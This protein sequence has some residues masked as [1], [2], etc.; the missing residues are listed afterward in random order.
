[1]GKITLLVVDDIE[2]NR[3]I[4]RK[5]FEDNYRILQASNGE[6][7]MK[8]VESESVEIV[9]TD[10]FMEP[11]NGYELIKHIR[12]KEQYR[13]IPIIAVTESD[14]A[15]RKKALKAGADDLIYRPFIR[16]I[17]HNRVEGLLL[18]GYDLN[19]YKLAYENNPIPF[20]LYHIIDRPDVPNYKIMYLNKAA[21]EGFSPPYIED[22][23][24]TDE[25]PELRDFLLKAIRT[26]EIQRTAIYE[27]ELKKWLDWTV[28]PDGTGLV[29]AMIHD[30]TVEIKK[31]TETFERNAKE[32]IRE[33]NSL[34]EII[35]NIPGGI[36][37]FKVS[38][39]DI[40]IMEANSSGC[41][42]LAV[43]PV[44]ILGVHKDT[45]FSF[46]HSGD[47]PA[48]IGAMEVLKVPETKASYKCR[49]YNR[50]KNE[51]TWFSAQAYSKK[52]QDGSVY[53]FINYTDITLE[54]E[55]AETKT[56]LLAAQ[57]ANIAKT[58]FMSRVS[59]DMRTPLNGILGLT[60]LLKEKIS[61]DDLMQ[62]LDQLLMSG[63]YLLNLIN[64]TLDVSKIESGKL[65][66]NPTVCDGRSVFNNVISLAKPNMQEKN[67][68]FHVKAEN[69]P[70][71]ILYLDVGRV[72][73]IAMNILSNA[74]KFTPEGGT[75]EFIMENVSV[76]DEIITDR[77]TI[78]DSGVGMS[79]EFLPHLFE[80]F[81]Q[82]NNGNKSTSTGSGLGMTIVK[83]ILEIMGGSITVESE[84]GKGTAFIFTIPMRIASEEQIQEWQK[85][86]TVTLSGASLEKK[87]V[88]LCEDHP[89][90]AKI[91][92][93][94]LEKKGMLVEHAENGEVGVAMFNDSTS[95]YYD[96]VL[97]DIRMPIM[98]G[99]E[100]TRAIRALS[101]LDAKTVPIVALTANAFEADI[102]NAKE[103]GM[104][105]HLSKPINT[106][107][108]YLTIEKLLHL[109]RHYKRKKIL[110]VDD[111]EVNRE[112]IKVSLQE[113]YVLLEASNG[114]EAM[115]LLE[116][117]NGIDAVITDIQMP[118]MNGIELIK[119]IRENSK[120]RNIVILANTQYGDPKQ[121]EE[122]LDLGA[123]DFVYKPTTPMIVKSRVK[124]ALRKL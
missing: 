2:M 103:A 121:E 4:V 73:Q 93:R 119:K 45:I 16:S 30:I 31:Q 60:S 90:N 107:K 44:K 17:L 116:T 40:V 28:Y 123:N 34:S 13:K 35:E 50:T 71:T 38:D 46:V 63:Q 23:L 76:K 53:A 7:A 6:E 108:L 113:D 10:V 84:L 102:Q 74:I 21:R 12:E 62:D 72:E 77:I 39:D 18:D 9:I 43:D 5:I 109:K 95:N 59:H 52:Q 56:E 65:E 99:L 29:A 94:L 98:D 120:Y 1:M 25:N 91:A 79:R 110:I 85:A 3:D 67:L 32:A 49:I 36:F 83:Q 81:S 69:L 58:D 96:I 106:E 105:G 68:H 20:V 78:K 87:R 82:E 114:E 61:D 15:S 64:D 48:V 111:M 26:G 101:R 51:Y 66:L 97:M 37:V 41:R 19:R 89:L 33:K 118:K 14:Q 70:F 117:N 122:L 8:I 75:I 104:D 115:A 55:L 124:N 22:L 42:M 27:P 57:K 80:P 54:K 24:Q 86:K 11:M 47:L 92:R 100:A 112:V 88:L